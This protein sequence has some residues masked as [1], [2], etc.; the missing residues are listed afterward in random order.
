MAITPDEPYNLT[1]YWRYIFVPLT[2]ITLFVVGYVI[3][4]MSSSQLSIGSLPPMSKLNAP[5]GTIPAGS[6]PAAST[7]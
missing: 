4:N 1:R 5:G 7:I 3:F 2:L 6:A